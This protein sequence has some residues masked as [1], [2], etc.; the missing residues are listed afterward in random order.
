MS[1]KAV[2]KRSGF[3]LIELLVVIAIIG[4]LVSILAPSLTEA[5]WQAKIGKCQAGLHVIGVA[6]QSYMTAYGLDTPWPFNNG[7]EDGI[8][9]SSYNQAFR[10]NSHEGNCPGNPAEALLSPLMAGHPRCDNPAAWK[11]LPSFLESGEPLFCAADTEFT[12]EDDFNVWGRFQP[13]FNDSVW[14]TYPYVYPHVLTE[15]DPFHPKNA[16][17]LSHHNSITENVGQVGRLSKNLVMY[18]RFDKVRTHFNS[19]QLN[20]VVEVVAQTEDE[21]EIYLWGKP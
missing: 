1:T 13:G 12:F 17:R 7:T 2:L 9:S 15:D 14:S 10:D 3:T 21:M 4:L 5:K 18:D 8:A 16:A 11:K 19:L 20:G 6:V